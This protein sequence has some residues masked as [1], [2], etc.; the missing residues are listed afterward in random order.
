MAS[1]RARKELNDLFGDF[2]WSDESDPGPDPPPSATT[3]KA[4]PPATVKD[5]RTTATPPAP[6]TDRPRPSE[7]VKRLVPRVGTTIQRSDATNRRK[8]RLLTDPPPPPTNRRQ[9][10]LAKS[11]KKAP[12]ATPAP[13]STKMSARAPSQAPTPAAVPQCAAARA[14]PDTRGVRALS[15]RIPTGPA[16]PLRAVGV[17]PPPQIPVEVAPGT[18]LLVPHHAVHTTR[19]HRAWSTNG[20]WLL[21]FNADGSLRSSRLRPTTTDPPPQVTR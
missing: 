9:P 1:T 7:P 12:A 14:M 16:P 21:R 18:I 3:D 6:V 10:N 15:V 17:R 11:P 13:A 5:A 19:R 20:K 2:P 8:I 4:R